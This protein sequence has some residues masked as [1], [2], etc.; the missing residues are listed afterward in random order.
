M[1]KCCQLMWNHVASSSRAEERSGCRAVICPQEV[2]V[3]LLPAGA[4]GFE[5]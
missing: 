2:R 3:L 1:H 5:T 4:P